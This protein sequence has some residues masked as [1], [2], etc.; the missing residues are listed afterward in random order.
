[1]Q[2]RIAIRKRDGFA[3]VIATRSGTNARFFCAICVGCA[4]GAG[5]SLKP[6]T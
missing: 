5:D 2:E 6:T 4:F 1:V 3:T